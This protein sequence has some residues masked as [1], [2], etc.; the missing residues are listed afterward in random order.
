MCLWTIHSMTNKL[1]IL[2]STKR[3]TPSLTFGHF[4]S[5]FNSTSW[6][7]CCCTCS[8]SIL[9]RLLC[10]FSRI[11][12]CIYKFR[13]KKNGKLNKVFEPSL[14]Q[15]ARLLL[16]MS[17]AA[18]CSLLLSLSLPPQDAFSSTLSRLHTRN[19]LR[20]LMNCWR[21]WQFIAGS[22]AFN[23]GNVRDLRLH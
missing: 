3:T 23:L 4:P 22:M 11:F 13:L 7:R 19:F 15:P 5:R 10:T 2:S 17:F 12:M 21:L 20:D 8:G 9:R 18:L 6:R 16:Y 1:N 14:S